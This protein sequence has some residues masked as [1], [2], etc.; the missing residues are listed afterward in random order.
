MAS[1]VGLGW[2]TSAMGLVLAVDGP[3]AIFYGLAAASSIA[4]TPYRA[5][6]SA[7]LPSLCRTSDELAASNIGRGIVES[8]S[9]IVGPLLAA[10]LVEV[11]AVWTVFVAASVAAGLA[12]LAVVRLPY[13]R[14]PALAPTTRRRLIGDV[15]DGLRATVASP[16]ARLLLS[17][18][19]AQTF[20]RGCLNVFTVVLAFDVLGSGDSGVG[21]LQAAMG[22]G[23]VVGA[24]GAAQLVGARHMAGWFGVGVALWGIPLC[25][26]GALPS[27]PSSLAMVAVIG[28]GNALVDVALFTMLGRLVAD[29]VLARM[30]GVL[31]SVIAVT[32]ALGSIVAAVAIDLIGIRPALAS[33]GAVAPFV[34]LIAWRGL[35]H[36]DQ[37]LAVRQRELDVLQR[38][39]M[40]RTL[41]VPTIEHLARRI[42]PKELRPGEV[43]VREGT[44]GTRYYVI[45]AGRVEVH[46][47]GRLTRTMG[48][49]EG[50]GEISLLRNVRRTTTVRATADAPVALFAIARADFVLAVGGYAPAARTAAVTMEQW[51]APA[52]GAA[53][54]T[55]S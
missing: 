1:N 29:A 38:V 47:R 46:Q 49:G 10:A 22:G 37:S 48:P 9:V 17:I 5:A 53:T 8:L 27:V 28:L 39:P 23:A 50:F 14:P 41:P 15:V 43:V 54:G 11:A 19:A 36:M 32:V 31:E 52:G 44:L 40:L 13:E 3:M 30:F 55:A 33:L 26:I 21:V 4:L 12:A 20:T 2:A 24:I 16:D 6:H 42:T 18:T 45:A 7:L 25:V 34:V 35:S 51:Q